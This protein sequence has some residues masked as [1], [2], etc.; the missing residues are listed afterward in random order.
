LIRLCDDRKT[1]VIS[2]YQNRSFE[3][4]SRAKLASAPITSNALPHLAATRAPKAYLHENE[5]SGSRPAMRSRFMKNLRKGNR[6]KDRIFVQTEFTD[7]GL[8]DS[9][10]TG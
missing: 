1:E 3:R 8:H 6:G 4:A 9:S 10:A 5:R 2:A 7:S